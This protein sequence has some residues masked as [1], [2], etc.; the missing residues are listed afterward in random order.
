MAAVEFLLLRRFALRHW[1]LAP[2]QSALLVL[3]LALGVGVFTSIRLANRAAV[4]SFTHFTETLT[5]QSD[6]IIQAPAGPLPEEPFRAGQTVVIQ[7]NVVTHDRKAG[8]QTGE[9]VVITKSGIESLHAFPRGFA[10]V[11]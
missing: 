5:G 3:I 1:R 4:A 9:L 11:G 2:G 10:R 6:W 7:P 8:V